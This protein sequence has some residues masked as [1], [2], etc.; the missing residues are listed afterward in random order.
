MTGVFS[1]P[2]AKFL[3]LN[4]FLDRFLVLARPVIN[5]LA[6]RALQLY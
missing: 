3:Q 6:L 5:A 2:I 1:A 4:L